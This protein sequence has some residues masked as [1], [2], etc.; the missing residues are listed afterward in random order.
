MNKDQILAAIKGTREDES[1]I[2]QQNKELQKKAAIQKCLK[3]Q[4]RI[5]EI[6]QK[7]ERLVKERENLVRK[8]K[9]RVDHHQLNSSE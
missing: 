7:I 5:E 1:E 3:A 9:A 4:E 2:K 8:H 6:D